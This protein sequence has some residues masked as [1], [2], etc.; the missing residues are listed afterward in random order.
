MDFSLDKYSPVWDL[1]KIILASLLWDG[2]PEHLGRAGG[3]L[4][5]LPKCV[6]FFDITK[7]S[8]PFCGVIAWL[9]NHYCGYSF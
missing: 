9:Y 8:R 6:L 2:F 5:H 7:S 4:D 1:G 3:P